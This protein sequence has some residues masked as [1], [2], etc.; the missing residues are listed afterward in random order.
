MNNVLKN[1]CDLDDKRSIT[2]NQYNNLYKDFSKMH[3]ESFSALTKEFEQH[4]KFTKKYKQLDEVN[5]TIWEVYEDAIDGMNKWCENDNLFTLDKK[6]CSTAHVTRN[7]AAKIAAEN[8]CSMCLD[9]HDIKHLIKTSCGHYFGKQCF[10]SL[11]KHKFYAN[12]EVIT[13][14]NCRSNNFSLQQFKYKK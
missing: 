10:A 12:I 14:P 9:T 5:K 13:C 2:W 8:C 7:K 1:I 6:V 3:D 11:L 4:E